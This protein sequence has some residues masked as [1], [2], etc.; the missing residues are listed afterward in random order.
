MVDWK[1]D[2]DEETM[3]FTRRIRARPSIPRTV[4][5]PRDVPSKSYRRATLPRRL[6][7]LSVKCLIESRRLIGT[8]RSV[9]ASRPAWRPLGSTNGASKASGRT[10][11]Q[12]S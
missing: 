4:A 2:L 12:P 11:Q 10:M 7:Y 5:E 6:E 3:E 9:R 8:S 1:A